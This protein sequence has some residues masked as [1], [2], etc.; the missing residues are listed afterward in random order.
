MSKKRYS[1]I[2]SYEK[3]NKSLD[4]LL[5]GSDKSKIQLLDDLVADKLREKKKSSRGLF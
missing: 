5:M 4:E 1:L 2:R 3:T